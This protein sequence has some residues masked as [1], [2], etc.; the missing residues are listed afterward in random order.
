MKIEKDIV[1][2]I[3]VGV[4]IG[5]LTAFLTLFLPKFLSKNPSSQTETE[6][7]ETTNE[8]ELMPILS[9]ESSLTLEN[10]QS[11]SIFSEDKITVSGKTRANALLVVISPVDEKAIEA[12]DK[13]NFETEISLEEGDNEITITVYTDDNQEETKSVTVYYSEEEI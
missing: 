4:V 9:A 3:I 8:E 12:D 6:K 11:E 2:A 7:T 13:G 10:P 1:L 5:G